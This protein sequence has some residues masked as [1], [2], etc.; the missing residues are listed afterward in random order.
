M[1]RLELSILY[2]GRLETAYREIS[3]GFAWGRKNLRVGPFFFSRHPEICLEF[4]WGLLG[5]EPR[6]DFA[7]K[8]GKIF[9]GI[10]FSAQSLGGA[11]FVCLGC[12]GT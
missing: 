5:D 1:R 8:L 6:I 3:F 2:L 10:D 11:V 4:A 9:L 7:L 12:L